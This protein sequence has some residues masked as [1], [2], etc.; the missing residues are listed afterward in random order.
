MS[1]SMLKGILTLCEKE[2]GN[3]SYHSGF[4]KVKADLSSFTPHIIPERVMPLKDANAKKEAE[5][6]KTLIS[7]PCVLDELINE[8]DP[9][10]LLSRRIILMRAARVLNVSI[11]YLL[12]LTDL[13]LW[14]Y[15]YVFDNPFYLC[16]A[17]SSA[18]LANIPY[19]KNG[20]EKKLIKMDKLYSEP[21]LIHTD[22]Q[23]IIFS[24]GEEVLRT[25]PM[26][27][28]KFAVPIGP[29]KS[30]QLAVKE[31]S[32][33]TIGNGLTGLDNFDEKE[34]FNEKGIERLCI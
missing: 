24:D 21:I 15:L 23:H 17:G 33:R 27:N 9:E 13:P 34:N 14:E 10:R 1:N 19:D 20:K 5:W 18:Y 30:L 31:A 11:D 28:G 12:G 26:F 29:E 7:N 22:K 3:I 6:R 16:E 25:D 32:A 4:T 8:K 2:G